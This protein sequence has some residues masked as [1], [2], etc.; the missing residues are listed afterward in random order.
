MVTQRLKL[1][2][3]QSL[4][5]AIFVTD[6]TELEIQIIVGRRNGKLRGEVLVYDSGEVVIRDDKTKKIL[7]R[8][9]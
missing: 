5:S 8:L 3:K 9:S 7:W 6:L 1:F 2:Q 4:K